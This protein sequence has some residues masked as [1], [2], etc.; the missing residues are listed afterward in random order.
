MRG[1]AR[2]R[3]AVIAVLGLLPATPQAQTVRTDRRHQLARVYDAIFDA[4]FD[5]VPAASRRRPAPPAPPEACQLLDVVS[6]WWQ[7]QLDPKNRMHDEPFRTR[8]MP[9]I[10]DDRG[11]DRREPNAGRGLVLPGRRLRGARAVAR[12]ARQ[13]LAAARDG[14]RI[15]DALERALALDPSLQDAYFGIGLYHYYADVAPAALRMLRWLLLLPGGDRVQGLEEMLR[16]R[17]DGQLLQSEADYQLHL[18]YLWYEKQP[19]G[20][21]SSCA[22]CGTAIR[23][24]RMFPQL[25]ADIQDVYSHDL[26][27]ACETWQSLLDAAQRNACRRTGDD[28][29]RRAR[30]G[31]AGC[32]IDCRTARRR[33]RTCARSRRS[34]RRPSGIVARA[35]LQLG[36][37]SIILV[38][39]REALSAYRAALAQRLAG[40]PDRIASAARA[41]AAK[42]R[43]RAGRRDHRARSIAM[44]CNR[45][46]ALCPTLDIVGAVGR[47]RVSRRLDLL[48][49]NAI[50]CLT[51]RKSHP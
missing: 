34:P 44:R 20:R 28:R 30:L 10:A 25:I 21:C 22:T 29:G 50:L 51:A 45:S 12:A 42:A 37:R 4:R 15:K 3:G 32:S 9:S 7:I 47:G 31:L 43:A 41:R 13:R 11:L 23:E 46:R 5:E 2:V 1:A 36:R 38:G 14:K 19:R 27:P 24:I 18:I 16:A 40:D 35:Q 49:S 39:A 33:S 48:T 8:S 17:K 6:L 26:Q